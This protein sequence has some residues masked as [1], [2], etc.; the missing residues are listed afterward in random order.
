[1]RCRDVQGR[2]Y[3]QTGKNFDK[4]SSAELES[5]ILNRCLLTGEDDTEISKE[6]HKRQIVVQNDTR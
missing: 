4:L 5:I 1:M 2:L 3:L 6:V